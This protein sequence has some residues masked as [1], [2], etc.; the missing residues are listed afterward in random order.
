MGRSAARD[1][2]EEAV[3]AR[4]AA[5]DPRSILRAADFHDV[6][7]DVTD[8]VARV[9]AEEAREAPDEE[10]LAY[11]ERKVRK[12]VRRCLDRYDADA[13]APSRFARAERVV[14]RVGGLRA[15]CAGVVAS[16][17]VED[18]EEEG[19]ARL[20]Y[21]VK[22]DPPSRRLISVP[23]DDDDLCR[24]EVCFGSRAGALW[25]T[26]FCMAA[27]RAVARRFAM[28]ERVVVA[29]EEDANDGVRW[30]AGTIID[31]DFSIEAD[32]DALLP[33]REWARGEDARVPYRVQLDSGGR[34]LVHRDEHW[35][36]RDPKLQDEGPASTAKRTRCLSR[37]ETRHRGDYTFEAIDHFTRRVQPCDAPSDSDHDCDDHCGCGA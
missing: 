23:R 18:P 15:W 24:A 20:P 8:R 7:C 25:F 2:V 35:L 21:V 33:S 3:S 13:Q 11:V 17:G 27:G 31:T 6:L 37:I 22:L 26:A 9:M 28:G 16:V 10:D 14:C 5:C 29:V 1:A 12:L 19:G 34:V 30:A 32:A 36:I 4:I